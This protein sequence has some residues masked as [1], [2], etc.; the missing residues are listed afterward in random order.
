MLF[1]VVEHKTCRCVPIAA[2]TLN[3]ARMLGRLFLLRNGNV[4]EVQVYRISN[5]KEKYIKES[6]AYAWEDWKKW[7]QESPGI[8]AGVYSK[9]Y[10][11]HYN[12][13][14]EIGKL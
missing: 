11:I 12:T 10:D 3:Q 6:L 2:E 14:R 8:E 5:F 1:Y 13:L 9:I 7:F 4:R